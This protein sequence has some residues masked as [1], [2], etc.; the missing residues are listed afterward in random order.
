MVLK[1]TGFVDFTVMEELNPSNLILSPTMTLKVW[2][3]DGNPFVE[4]E[5]WKTREI[6]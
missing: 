1:Y 6:V 2:P 4:Q 3:V 5:L